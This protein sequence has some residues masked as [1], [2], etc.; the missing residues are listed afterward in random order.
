MKNSNFTLN[1]ALKG[2]LIYAINCF[3]PITISGGLISRNGFQY[4]PNFKNPEIFNLKQ[5]SMGPALD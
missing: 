3:N 2:S 1:L 4:H 5:D